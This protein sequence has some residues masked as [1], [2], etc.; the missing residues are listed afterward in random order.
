MKKYIYTILFCA[1]TLT[2]GCT[3]IEQDVPDSA[4]L[5]SEAIREPKDVENLLN[6][7]YDALANR[8]NGTVQTFND[9]MSDDLILNISD[10]GNK[11]EI[12]NR[13]TI[14]FNDDVKDAYYGLYLV[15]S[16]VNS[17]DGLYKKVG[18]SADQELILRAEGRFLRGLA[19]F[20]VAKL[21][22]QPPGFTSD[23]SH[24]G[25]VI[26]S[27]VSEFAKPRATLKSSYDFIIEDLIYAI[28]NL[29]PKGAERPGFA[30][31]NAA[32]ALLAKVYFMRNDAGDATEAIRLIG[33][34]IPT[35][36]LSK[37]VNHYNN[38]SSAGEYIFQMI[39]ARVGDNRGR[40]FIDQYRCDNKVPAY[41]ITKELFMNL[42][43]DTTDKRGKNLVKSFNTG[44]DNEYFG[45]TKFNKDYLSVPYLLLTDLLLTRAELYA[46]NGNLT[47]AADDV[48]LI[49]NRAYS[50]P[51]GK[52]VTAVI[53]KDALI[54][55]IRS[56]RRLE[57][58]GEGDR[59]QH[60]KRR[61]YNPAQTIRNGPWNCPGLVLQ[62]HARE[63]GVG[64]EFNGTGGCN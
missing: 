33:E 10:A 32:K 54:S 24:N 18:V 43:S 2:F 1:V 62:F 36:T 27:E 6:S 13:S 58:F 21:W 25:I 12:Y 23:N 44:K 48:N 29:P 55:R 26:R 15:C 41:T 59:L 37:D 22:A 28:N 53:R 63:A 16:R 11:Q 56:E 14:I 45:I 34:V 60:L 8:L 30:N 38:D 49:I 7:C 5:E 17:M 50:D 39:S 51:T 19:H 47:A 3:K 52:I 61:G 64:F 40:V 42:T 9:L 46:E 57:F 20:E 4:F 31:K 35:Y